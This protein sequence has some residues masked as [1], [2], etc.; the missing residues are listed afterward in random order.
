MTWYA[1]DS[2][3]AMVSQSLTLMSSNISVVYTTAS[4]LCNGGTGSITVLTASS[5]LPVSVSIDNGTSWITSYPYT[6][7]TSSSSA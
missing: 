7:T 2:V 5:D 1:I 4:I 3:G 6:F